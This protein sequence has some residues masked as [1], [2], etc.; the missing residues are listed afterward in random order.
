MQKR[1]CLPSLTRGILQCMNNEAF[2]LIGDI[3]GEAAALRDLLARLGYREQ[4]GCFRHP[5]RRVIFLGDYIDRGPAVRE[6]LW[7][8]RRMVEE[9]RALALCGNHELDVLMHDTPD[10]AGGWL[11]ARGGRDTAMHERTHADFIERPDEWQD[12]LRWFQTLPLYLDLPGLRAA[13]AYLSSACIAALGDHRCLDDEI[14]R[15]DRATPLGAAM[16]LILKG[17]SVLL[18][19]ERGVVGSTKKVRVRWWA[20]EPGLTYYEFCIG[21]KGEESIGPE[22][23]L[24]EA[25]QHLLVPTDPGDDRPVFIGHYWLS[26]RSTPAPLTPK[27]ACLDYSVAHGGPLVAYRWNGER[28]LRPDGFV[29]DPKRSGVAREAVAV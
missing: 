29:F 1:P 9:G 23:P 20:A 8:V 6:T 3:H 17:P 4:C 24:R 18:P 14:L 25:D 21:W 13:H 16:H 10:G 26:P 7:I 15:T 12:W 27:V 19:K 5:E 11:R 28:V 22:T 2:D